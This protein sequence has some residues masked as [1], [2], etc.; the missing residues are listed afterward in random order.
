MSQLAE[1]NLLLQE[2]VSKARKNPV[3]GN[4]MSGLCYVTVDQGM[5]FPEVS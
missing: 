2:G 5:F 1:R 3:L 4:G